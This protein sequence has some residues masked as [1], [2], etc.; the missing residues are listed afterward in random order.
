MGPEP[1]VSE[2]TGDSSAD[3]EFLEISPDRRLRLFGG[4]TQ[5]S[6]LGRTGRWRLL[7]TNEELVVFQRL[8]DDCQQFRMPPGRV[9]MSGN[10]GGLISPVELISFLQVARATCWATFISQNTQKTLVFMQ[11]NL[12]AVQSNQVQDRL[13]EVLLRYGY[14]DRPTL[15][16]ALQQVGPQRP[17]GRVLQEQGKL[18]AHEL[19]KNIRRQME[20]VFFSLIELSS[21][22]FHVVDGP[23]D[24]F[25]TRMALNTQGLVL[26][27]LKRMDEMRQYRK[28]LP[29]D[30]V[31]IALSP[32][33]CFDQLDADTQL[34]VELL[35]LR[36]PQPLE[37][38]CR[39]TMLGQHQGT[40]VVYAALE[41]GL[42]RLQG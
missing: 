3:R 42:V 6:L 24:K 14:L 28:L 31:M 36:G 8:P 34:V 37:Q 23:V 32:T 25:P 20:E 16:R 39:D 10:L 18:T 7:D 40:R 26:E 38:L 35:L 21:G 4:H 17:L 41:S 11:G 27:G 5:R 33:G 30:Q 9:L 1:A 13:G 12:L 19:W 2:P 15:D 22:S 29:N